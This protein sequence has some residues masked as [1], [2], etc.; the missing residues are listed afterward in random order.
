L[1]NHLLE[2]RKKSWEENKKGLSYYDQCRF[3][4]YLKTERKTLTAIHSQVIQDVAMRL[5]LAFKSFFRRVKAGEKPGYPRF[6]GKGWY[7]SIT[8]PQA[9]NGCKLRDNKLSVSKIGSIKIKLSRDLVGKPVIVTIKRSI[10]NKWYVSF[11]QEIQPNHLP[12]TN[13]SVGI[14]VGLK[15]FATLSDGTEIQNPRFFKSEDKTLINAQRKLSKTEKGSKERIN[16]RKIVARV[17]ERIINKRDDFSHKV[18]TQIINLY[19]IICVE[20]LNINR[21]QENN[22]KCINKSI[23]DVAWSGFFNKLSY[24]AENAGRKLIKVNPAYTTQDCH[25]CGHRQK[26]SLSDRTYECPCCGLVIDRDLNAAKNILRLGTQSQK[27]VRSRLR[28]ARTG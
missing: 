11:V 12:K 25:R 9:I 13:K 8:F 1:Y 16:R 15:T 19:D 5:D 23:S 14:D 22:F 26:M 3:I 17:H 10:T 24:K 18:S 2:Q 28:K 21:M 6:K 4:V 27:P 7:D 20:D